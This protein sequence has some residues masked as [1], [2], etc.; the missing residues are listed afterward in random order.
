MFFVYIYI[1]YDIIMTSKDVDLD[2]F[3]TA[4]ESKLRGP[5]SS[6]DLTKTIT[7]PALRGGNDVSESQYLYQIEQILSKPDKITQM[8]ILIGL[9]GLNP[10]SELDSVVYNIIRKAQGKQ[11][12]QD[13]H[14]N[15]KQNNNN[16]EREEEKLAYR[17]EEWVQ[18]IAGLIQGIMFKENHKTTNNNDDNDNNNDNN[19]ENGNENQSYGEKAKD[20]LDS[21]CDEI[22]QKVEKV[23]YNQKLRILKN[24]KKQSKQQ[25]SISSSISSSTSSVR[26]SLLDADFDPLMAP[27]KYTLLNP[28]L[29]RHIIPDSLHD[30]PHFTVN[31]D[32]PI[33]DIDNQLEISRAREESEHS[34]QTKNSSLSSQQRN[35]SSDRSSASSAAAATPMAYM[36]GMNRKRPG[37]S[38]S[39]STATTT[40]TDAKK[41]AMERPKTS[42]F[43]T[44]KKPIGTM[45]S[46]GGPNAM[47]RN[48]GL[49]VRKTGA[50]Q[51]LVGKGRQL[52]QPMSST[53]GSAATAGG[54]SRS[55]STSTAGTTSRLGGSGSGGRALKAMGGGGDGG[56]VSRSKMK[57]I[58]DNEASDLVK[59]QEQQNSNTTSTKLIGSKRKLGATSNLLRSNNNNNNKM[60]RGGKGR[61]EEKMMMISNTNNNNNHSNKQP[62]SSSQ[63]T[64]SS[65]KDQNDNEDDD[66]DE[67]KQ[68]ERRRNRFTT[69]T[70]S[71]LSKKEKQQNVAT[72]AA[73]NS[74]DDDDDDDENDDDPNKT[75]NTNS[76]ATIATT[77]ALAA[78]ALSKYQSQVA[79]TEVATTTTEPTTTTKQLNWQKL[80]NSKSN[81]LTESDRERIQLFFQSRTNPTPE[82]SIYKMKLHEDRIND[83]STG[84]PTMKETYYLEL[85][86][87]N[88][89][90][91]Q[92]KK[93]KRY[94]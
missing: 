12:E 30:N 59:H 23:A 44:A 51:R 81:R 63:N 56:G 35:G 25:S 26:K 90:S 87:N 31:H 82:Q 49:H 71:S 76:A 40:T 48:T 13:H 60:S 45:G 53:I 4:I 14:D 28:N 84:K 29:L 77:N 94:D 39:S 46:R 21:S 74:D 54:S 68:N 61:G 34:I 33:L 65:D 36:P 18:V 37:T 41:K 85:N 38:S 78:E 57:M 7:T 10:K 64:E 89:T 70:S 73:L 8:R 22:I 32:A 52:Q 91:K 6:L 3:V 69:A 66:D 43:L 9:L 5:F 16:N 17:Y 24:E 42:M 80:L 1:P 79:A 62:S 15:E 83:V 11:P 47:K 93:V 72:F 19:N 92:S 88:Y 67:T 50:A 55:G 27:Y 2:L 58:D 75:N 86:Y 20:L